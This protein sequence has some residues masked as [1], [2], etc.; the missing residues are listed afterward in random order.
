MAIDLRMVSAD[1]LAQSV[2]PGSLAILFVTRP[3]IERGTV[4]D[5]V[6]RLMAMTDSAAVTR[7]LA[8]SVVLQVDGYNHDPR[9]L[10]EI[11]EVCAFFKAIDAQWS[12]WAHFLDIT[13]SDTF[14]ML[15]SLLIRPKRQFINGA[16]IGNEYDPPEVEFFLIKQVR[17]AYQLHQL[18]GLPT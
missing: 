3:E 6:D 7:N 17:A 9:E 8:G 11:P 5:V 16:V 1:T 12:F 14:N 10:M 15:I 13:L 18:H 2:Q 4:G